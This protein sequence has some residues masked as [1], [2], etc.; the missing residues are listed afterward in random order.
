MSGLLW[1]LGPGYTSTSKFI[2]LALGISA[3]GLFW[4]TLEEH[5]D[6]LLGEGRWLLVVPLPETSE[7][8]KED[9]L[10]VW[11]KMKLGA[12]QVA[13]EKGTTLL[14]RSILERGMTYAGNL[15][16]KKGVEAVAE[17][18]ETAVKVEKAAH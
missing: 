4:A 11:T 5:R 15:W 16:S 7:K 3:S 10:Q 13:I 12:A 1:Q 18:A 6:V 2:G 8:A 14:G 17:V 9:A